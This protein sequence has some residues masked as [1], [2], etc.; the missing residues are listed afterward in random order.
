VADNGPGIPLE[1]RDKIFIP[2]Y[3][4]K[5]KGTGIGLS[6][7]RQIIYNHAGRLTFTS[8]PDTSTVF[9]LDF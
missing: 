6:L 8:D 3:S 7:S 2:F 1:I 4:T 9:T 5:D